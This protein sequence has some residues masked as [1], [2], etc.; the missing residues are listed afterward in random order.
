MS[1]CRIARVALLAGCVAAPGLSIG[2]GASGNRVATYVEVTADGAII[3][4][5]APAWD[6]PDGC[7]D[8]FRIFIPADNV[9]IDRYYAAVL[10]AYSSGDYV[11]AW[12]EGCRDM[13]WGENYPVVKNIATRQR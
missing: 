3:I 12:V 6:N 2:A 1:I 5:A 8:P 10:T 4:E 11:W 13:S 9:F 7:G